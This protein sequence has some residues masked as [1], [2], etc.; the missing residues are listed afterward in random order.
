LFIC[1]DTWTAFARIERGGGGWRNGGKEREKDSSDYQ[2]KRSES[3]ALA[4]CIFAAR[5]AVATDEDE[6]EAAGSDCR[7]KRS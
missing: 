2:K 6:Y 5:V 3:G 4:Y 7:V 1:L